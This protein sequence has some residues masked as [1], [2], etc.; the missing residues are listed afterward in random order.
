MRPETVKTW[1]KSKKSQKSAFL[2]KTQDAEFIELSLEEGRT[3]KK[4][5]WWV[6]LLFP[7]Q[8]LRGG[9]LTYSLKN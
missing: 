1:C 7:K 6:I 4:Q 5:D 3:T 9:V 8:R 2:L